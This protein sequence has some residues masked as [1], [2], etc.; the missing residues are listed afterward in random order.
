MKSVPNFRVSILGF[1][2]TSAGNSENCCRS[3]EF[4]PAV[5][6]REFHG[7]F[8]IDVSQ[9][10][11]VSSGEEPERG[12]GAARKANCRVR[13]IEAVGLCDA[14]GRFSRNFGPP[15]IAGSSSGPS[16]LVALGGLFATCH[17]IVVISAQQ[18]C[19]KDGKAELPGKDSPAIGR[20]TCGRLST[21]LCGTAT[22][23]ARMDD[24]VAS[25]SAQTVLGGVLGGNLA[26]YTMIT[27]RTGLSVAVQS[28][29]RI[30]R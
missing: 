13:R 4:V 28:I 8:T 5:A 2:P 14:G 3:L 26:F 7:P 29:K 15:A 1:T 11:F 30:R 24:H 10:R 27:S 12:S 6:A 9:I 21:V 17:F 22:S 16:C 19:A 25:V 23:A 18:G 20:N